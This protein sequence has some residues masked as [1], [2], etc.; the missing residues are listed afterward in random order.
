MCKEVHCVDLG[1]SFP[2]S[3]YLQHLASIP[4]HFLKLAT[5]ASEPARQGKSSV[6]S[7]FLEPQ[8]S[9]FNL[10]IP[11]F[12]SD[13]SQPTRR[14]LNFSEGRNRPVRPVPADPPIPKFFGRPKP[15]RPTRLPKPSRN[16]PTRP[17]ACHRFLNLSEAHRRTRRSLNFSE[18]RNRP[19]RPA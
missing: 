8:S 17:K 9:I 18:S 15:S 14:S 19:F 13:P 16:R 6:F 4:K 7:I 12:Q 5:S 3:I 11:N 2:T 10:Q 1:E